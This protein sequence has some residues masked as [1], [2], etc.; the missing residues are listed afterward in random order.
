MNRPPFSGVRRLCQHWLIPRRLLPLGVFTACLL[1]GLQGQEQ[2]A[3]QGSAS[4]APIKITIPDGAQL[5]LRFVQPVWGPAR[6]ACLWCGS[7]GEARRGDHVRL[8]AVTE[9][10]LNETVVIEKGALARATVL[11]TWRTDP[12][13]D[14]GPGLALKLEW[15]KSVS[16]VEV[17]LRP[18]K[19]G[20]PKG[21]D[22]RVLSRTGGT[23]ASPD[24]FSRV[25]LGAM[26]LHMSEIPTVLRQRN[27]VPPGT[28]IVAFVHGA[29][30]LD[31][32]AVREAQTHMPLPN[33][34][35]MLTIFRT[36]DHR[37]ESAN[38]FCDGKAAP[39]IN[40][41]QFTIMELQPG[42]HSCTVESGNHLELMTESGEEYFLR[43]RP[44]TLSDGWELDR[45]SQGE[46]EDG[47]AKSL[48]A[49]PGTTA[50][51]SKP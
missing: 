19:N 42:L 37:H 25:L 39:E 6:R 9:V 29:I 43:L 32:A 15:V 41:Q 48:M 49:E 28:L 35:V 47:I 26:T 20:K 24:K 4:L 14:G 38:V 12:N 51:E 7:T 34:T 33:P 5:Q 18:S 50:S 10:R 21:F 44:R 16:G 17:P 8:V 13:H 40:M 45:V 11:K 22:V 2:S 36:K 1:T 46:G 30:D 31:A 23:V 27:W 3:A